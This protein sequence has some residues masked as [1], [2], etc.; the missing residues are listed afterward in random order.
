MLV[1]CT[2]N[3]FSESIGPCNSYLMKS[4]YPR[5][6]EYNTNIT[7]SD[8][9]VTVIFHHSL[10]SLG[11]Y[12]FTEAWHYV[13]FLGI[14]LCNLDR[15]HYRGSDILTHW[16]WMVSRRVDKQVVVPQSINDFTDKRA[17]TEWSRPNYINI[18]VAD[19]LAPWVARTS[20]T[21]I[22][23]MEN[24]KS[25]SYTRKDFN[26]LWHI[27]VEAWHGTRG[28]WVRLGQGYSIWPFTSMRY[29]N[30]LTS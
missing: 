14:E 29:T 6:P 11:N 4:S 9:V 30:G 28:R 8:L 18:M 26:D 22:L 5:G 3:L 16:G 25:W 7:P 15:R 10:R 20:G 1:C 24:I 19:A 13:F 21:M 27:N 17:G 23:T 12:F 2:R